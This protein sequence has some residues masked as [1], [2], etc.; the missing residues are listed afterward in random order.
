MS[1]Y[2]CHS[3][4]CY[5]GKLLPYKC[6]AIPLKHEIPGQNR[7]IPGSLDAPLKLVKSLDCPG[8]P[9]TVGNYDFDVNAP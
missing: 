5:R 6:I 9:W 3:C 4:N 8:H 7:A 1:V 2:A